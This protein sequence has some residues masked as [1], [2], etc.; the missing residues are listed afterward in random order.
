MKTRRLNLL[1]WFAILGGPLAWAAVHVAGYAVGLAQCDQPTARWSVPVHALDVAFAAAGIVVGLLA[2]AVA[3]WIFLATR[4]EGSVPPTGRVH[5]LSAIAL[6][7][8]PL[9]IAIML[10]IGVGTPFLHVCR[11]S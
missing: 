10:E 6:T 9:A 4:E 11:Q 7:V 5:F 2:E 8:N 1:L 3:L